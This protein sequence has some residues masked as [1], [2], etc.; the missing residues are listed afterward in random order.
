MQHLPSVWPKTADHPGHTPHHT[1]E[2]GECG[3]SPNG[4]ANKRYLAGGAATLPIKWSTP[5]WFS[6]LYLH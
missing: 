6:V 5:G 3:L 2:G 4:D 1:P